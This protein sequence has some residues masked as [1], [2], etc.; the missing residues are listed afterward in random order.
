MENAFVP[1]KTLKNYNSFYPLNNC[2][3]GSEGKI[4]Y[5]DCSLGERYGLMK[6]DSVIVYGCHCLDLL[7][8]LLGPTQ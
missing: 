6:G 4:K 8:F 3:T 2:H 5:G 1:G 7:S